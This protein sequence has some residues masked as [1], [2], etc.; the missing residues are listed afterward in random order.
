MKKYILF[1]NSDDAKKRAVSDYS[2][3]D[4]LQ[5]ARQTRYALKQK[6]LKMRNERLKALGREMY[7]ACQIQ[8]QDEFLRSCCKIQ[9]T[10]Q[11]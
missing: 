6:L 9:R 1:E 8:F 5:K 7:I 10:L 2:N 11:G 4:K 3:L